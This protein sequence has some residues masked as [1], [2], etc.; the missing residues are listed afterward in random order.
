VQSYTPTVA[1][2]LLDRWRWQKLTALDGKAPLCVAEAADGARWFGM[3]DGVM[4]YDGE[5]WRQYTPED[6]LVGKPATVLT[7]A[8]DGRIYAGSASGLSRFS[9][10][11][12][13]RVFPRT[14]DRKAQIY[15]VVASSDG[16]IW[17]GSDGFILKIKDQ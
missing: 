15:G 5:R 6:G 3:A 9:N 16:S 2:P 1:D 4:R 13:E 10:G 8:S 7:P 14:S 12:W 17:A 11:K